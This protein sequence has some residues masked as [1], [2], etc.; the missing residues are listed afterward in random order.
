MAK[1]EI[2]K[3]GALTV[4]QLKAALADVPDNALVG[5][6]IMGIVGHITKVDRVLFNKKL[7]ILTLDADK[8]QGSFTEDELC[9]NGFET[10]VEAT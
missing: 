4:G 3:E 2:Y 8:H 1:I 9:D 7:G 5:Q 10:K 6:S